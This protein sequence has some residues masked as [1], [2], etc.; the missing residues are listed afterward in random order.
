MPTSVREQILARVTA[1]LTSAAPG[2][3]QVFRARETSLARSLMPVITVLLAGETDTAMSHDVDRHQLRVTLAVFVRGD[4]W[5]QLVDAVATP[6][7][8]VVMS[9]A[10]LLALVQR[11]RKV[12]SEP[13]AE[14]ADRTAG[15]LSCIYELT[16]LTRA[17]DISAPA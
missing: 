14:E 12:S 9:D 8:S 17:G 4:P 5:D 3:A 16:Y 15:V 6:M 11:V 10:P 1:A 13:E 7:H 2:G